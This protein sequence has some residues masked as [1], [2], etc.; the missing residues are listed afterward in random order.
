MFSDA[1][2]GRAMARSTRLPASRG[3]APVEATSASTGVTCIQSSVLLSGNGGPE[4]LNA[5]ISQPPVETALGSEVASMTASMHALWRLRTGR[6]CTTRWLEGK[7]VWLQWVQQ[8]AAGEPDTRNGEPLS[9]EW[10][11]ADDGSP[12]KGPSTLSTRLSCATGDSFGT[13]AHM[14]CI[15]QPQSTVTTA[16]DTRCSGAMEQQHV[17]R[18]ACQATSGRVELASELL[19]SRKGE[20]L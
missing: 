7:V 2:C 10:C 16:V 14:T 3:T 8:I 6:I 5:A 4:T 11:K 13:T 12:L 9:V 18:D 15:R 20:C 17:K 19:V 1:G